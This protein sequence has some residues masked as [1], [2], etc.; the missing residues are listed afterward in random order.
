M[1]ADKAMFE[2][3]MLVFEEAG[4]PYCILAGYD[5]Y[6]EVIP[7][8]V[9]FMLAPDWL[10]RLPA[11]VAAAAAR[12][13][14]RLVQC[15]AHETTATYFALARF[16]GS[17][18]AWLHPDSSGDFR[19]GGRLW[20]RAKQVLRNRRRHRRGFWIPA[21]GDAFAYY[22]DKKLDKGSL[23]EE[24]AGQLAVR[25]A[26]DPAAC[27]RALCRVLPPEEADFVEAAAVT[28][29][30]SPV[31]GRV[32]SL[33]AA[34][35]RH[36]E[37]EPVLGRLAQ[38]ARELRRI[39]DRLIR[40]TGLFI[41]FLG[42]DGSGKSSVI[43]R[44]SAELS[45]AFRSVE[46]RHLRPPLSPWRG[47]EAAAPAAV[48]PH[49][50][51]PRGAPGSIA[52]LLVFW[53]AYLVGG[54]VWLYPRRVCSKLVIFDRY[55]H[56]VLA[57]PLRYRC[58]DSPWFA[59]LTRLLGRAVP[60]P[61]LVFVLDAAPEILQARKQEVP[62]AESA[63]QRAAYLRLAG[64]FRHV[65]VIDAGASCDRVAA[66]VLTHA[67]DALEARTRRRLGLDRGIDDERQ[68]DIPWKA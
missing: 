46:Y 25:F 10:G 20:L 7:S 33:R 18:I 27:R 63:R 32:A 14:S 68:G 64:E 29:R 12:S 19:R 17:R 11:L 43:E 2:A 34:M 13:G 42:P 59:R 16:D 49:A 54:L 26:E 58:P 28:G 36:V 21:A 62:F 41:V 45:Q 38:A 48:D 31:M 65:H 53:A 1:N 50:Q 4:M 8:D 61:D 66:S 67:I 15:L 5:G 39:V 22:L 3:L 52:K 47:S 60:Q 23:N 30:W 24:Q 37:R 56:D 44:V 57:D 55:Y 51:A 6:P 40:P 35:N 9:D